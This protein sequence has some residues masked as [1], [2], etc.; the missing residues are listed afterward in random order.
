[1]S[2]GYKMK[3]S[4]AI[5]LLEK[6]PQDKEIKGIYDKNG[7]KIDKPKLK[8]IKA[9]VYIAKESLDPEIAKGAVG[10]WNGHGTWITTK[11]QLDQDIPSGALPWYSLDEE[12]LSKSFIKSKMGKA[13]VTKL[14]AK[15]DAETNG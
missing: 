6:M 9:G 2:R 4:E 12:E 8:K 1:M 3:V 7:K 5:E 11:D 13:K 15:I 10:Y 14:L